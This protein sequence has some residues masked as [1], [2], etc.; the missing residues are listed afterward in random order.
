[1]PLT[2]FKLSSIGDGGITTAKLA[3]GAVTLTK[4]D[5]L[6]VNTEISGT[7]AA[8]MPVGTTAQRTNEQT[9][10]IRFNSTISLMEYYD[11]T[12]WKA[13]DSAPLVTSI[14]PTTETAANADIVITGQFFSSGATVKFVGNDG[15]EYASPSVT[16]TNATSIT[17]Q[18]PATVLTI[19]NEPYDIVVTNPSGLSGTLADALDAGG[20]PTWTTSSGSLMGSNTMYEGEIIESLSVAATDPDGDT[21]TYGVTSGD[22]LPAGLSLNTTTGAIEG[23]TDAVSGDTTTT[24]S[25]DAITDNATTARS[26]SMVTTNDA[27]AAY[28]SNLKLWLRAGWD[29]QS[30]GNQS[31]QTTP[32][33]K[34][35][36]SYGVSNIVNMIGTPVINTNPDASSPVNGTMKIKDAQGGVS[37]LNTQAKQDDPYAYQCD[38]GDSFWVQIPSGTS[39]FDTGTDHTITYWMCWEDRAANTGSNVFNPTFHS[40]GGGPNSFSWMAHD[41]YTNG[42][43]DPYMMHYS[44]GAYQGNFNLPSISG[45]SNGSKGV[46]FHIAMQYNS[47]GMYFFVNGSYTGQSLNSMGNMPSIGTNQ[48]CNFNGRGDGISGGLPGTYTTGDE[49][50]KSMADLRYYNATLSSP[51]IADIYNKGRSTFV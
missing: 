20:A 43:S 34:W 26:F 19:E 38:A 48:S 8:K 3:D 36:T 11:G 18:T 21:V 32:A 45:G 44:N 51:A 33:A 6:F 25:L 46:W 9:G 22:A 2:R 15:T 49:G 28:E 42:T 27:S 39:V 7:E 23:D 30:T 50:Y 4:T 12:G 14:S 1:M 40:W 13:I 24:F 16:F 47:S 17:A 37:G 10:D 35:G 29:G 31:G 41:W 5:S